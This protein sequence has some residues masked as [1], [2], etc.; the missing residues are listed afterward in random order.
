MATSLLGATPTDTVRPRSSRDPAA[1]LVG[2]GGGA[3]ELAEVVG[4][5]EVGL[6]EGQR[7]DDRSEEA[8]DGEDRLG[9]GA[10]PFELGFEED[11]VRTQPARLRRGKGRVDAVAAG[12]VVG[13]GDDPAAVGV[14]PHHHRFADEGG[15]V[16]HVDRGIEAVHVAVQDAAVVLPGIHGDVGWGWRV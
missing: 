5:I 1:D 13:G 4:D 10:I 8:V 6:V 2:D 9:L 3:A 12:L 15:V 7:L 16:P 11:R 14:A